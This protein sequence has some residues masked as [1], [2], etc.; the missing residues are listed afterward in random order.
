MN[1]RQAME[2]ALAALTAAQSEL[3]DYAQDMH[4]EDYNSPPLNAAIAALRARLDQPMQEGERINIHLLWRSACEDWG[5]AAGGP[6]EYEIF[7]EKLTAALASQGTAPL[8]QPQHDVHPVA[9]ASS[10][11]STVSAIPPEIAAIIERLHTQDNRITDNPLFAVQ[12]KRCIYGLDADHRDGTVFVDDEGIEF[13]ERDSVENGCREV[14]Y[15]DTWEFVTGC[16]TEQG[17]KDYIACN[18]HNLNEPR[19]Y[20]YGSYRNAEFIALRKWLMGLRDAPSRKSAAGDQKQDVQDLTPAPER[21][22]QSW[23]GPYKDAAVALNELRQAAAEIIGEDPQ[24][25]PDHGNATLAIAAALGLRTSALNRNAE[26]LSQLEAQLV[27]S[28]E[29]RSALSDELAQLEA[30]LEEMEA[31]LQAQDALDN[32]EL[33]GPNAEDYFTL[34]RRRNAARH[35]L[36]AAL[37]KEKQG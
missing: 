13:A 15:R 36:D 35:D 1:D 23:L 14:G 31:L 12:Q 29:I 18:G 5:N 9:G 32:R 10:E 30:L 26:R 19:I 8:E 17:C 33:Q 6:A 11:P 28:R 34:L 22:A 16:F 20:A 3:N 37:G 27:A 2:Q 25:W 21:I 24:T 4:S 7:A